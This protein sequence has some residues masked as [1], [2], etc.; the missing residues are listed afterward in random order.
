MVQFDYRRN[1]MEVNHATMANEIN[2][3][4]SLLSGDMKS[5]KM[6]VIV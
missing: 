5:C 2:A 1:E 6:T 3:L 4:F